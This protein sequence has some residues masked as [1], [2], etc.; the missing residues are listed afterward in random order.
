[1]PP[2]ETGGTLID[3]TSLGAVSTSPTSVSESISPDVDVDMFRFTITAGQV[4]DF[5]IDTAFNGPGGLGSFIRLFNSAGTQLD[6]NNDAAAPGET[7]VG[8]DAY[9]RYTFAAAGTYYLGVS[10]SNNSLY[11]P[12]SGN[13][14]TSG[15]QNSIGSYQLTVQ[16]IAA[17]ANDPDDTISEA[18][19]IGHHFCH[20]PELPQ[21]GPI[22]THHG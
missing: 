7:T 6:F 10:N 13:G 20:R 3:A 14:D 16:S 18:N 17:S 1:M 4:V 9:L 12:V 11:D 5:D 15:G 22:L 8:F 21:S 2:N 19:V